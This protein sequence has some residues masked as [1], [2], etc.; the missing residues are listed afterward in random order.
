MIIIC[1]I[2]P[3]RP[4]SATL[5]ALLPL[6]LL[7]PHLLLLLYHWLSCVVL[8]TPILLLVSLVD[9]LDYLDVAELVCDEVDDFMKE[10]SHPV[11]GLGGHCEMPQI[12]VPAAGLEV[13]LLDGLPESR[14]AYSVTA[15]RLLPTMMLKALYSLCSL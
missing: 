8:D 15:S 5:L 13:V 3:V 11:A 14:Q 4:P 9:L 12:F 10:F 2:P 6:P 7:Q 1:Y